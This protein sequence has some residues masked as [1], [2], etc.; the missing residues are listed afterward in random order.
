MHL[1]KNL[2]SPRI[3]LIYLRISILLQV[4]PL[5]RPR[6]HLPLT[7]IREI[8][9][10][11]LISKIPLPTSKVSRLPRSWSSWRSK[12]WSSKLS[13]LHLSKARCLPKSWCPLR[14]PPQSWCRINSQLK[15]C[16]TT[17]LRLFN[18][19]VKQFK[20]LLTLT[21][22]FLSV[23]YTIRRINL[24]QNICINWIL[25]TISSCHLSSPKKFAQLAASLT[26]QSPS[27]TSFREI[28]WASSFIW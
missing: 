13:R 2:L 23:L 4:K 19:L 20:F 22:W 5:D 3:W 15:M 1:S 16:K 24:Y 21:K 12:L 10:Q 28:D 14:T 11:T 26:S 9:N 6:D 17:N 25:R 8:K 18:P 27:L 7:L